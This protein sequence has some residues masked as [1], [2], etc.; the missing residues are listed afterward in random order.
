MHQFGVLVHELITEKHPQTIPELFERP[1]VLF[2]AEV[3]WREVLYEVGQGLHVV[4]PTSQ[5]WVRGDEAQ[6]C[7]FFIL[8]FEPEFVER[9]C[10]GFGHV[11]VASGAYSMLFW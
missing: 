11:G 5:G 3:D 6:T 9:L 10:V 1:I 8:D 4:L 2:R 7:S